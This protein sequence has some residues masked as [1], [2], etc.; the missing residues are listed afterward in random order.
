VSA[1]P[2][3]CESELDRQH[4]TSGDKGV[5]GSANLLN[6]WANPAALLAQK[7]RSEFT[8]TN[9]TQHKSKYDHSLRGIND[10]S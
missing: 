5:I 4:N 3:P 10:N 8:N 9:T 1:A 2:R 7:R 6:V